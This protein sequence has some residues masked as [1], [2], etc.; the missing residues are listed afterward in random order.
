MQHTVPTADEK[1]GELTQ[2]TVSNSEKRTSIDE[3][4]KMFLKFAAFLWTPT[5]SFITC[6]KFGGV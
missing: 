4:G 3:T 6:F 1:P 2:R 5:G